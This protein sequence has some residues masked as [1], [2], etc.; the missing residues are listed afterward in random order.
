MLIFARSGLSLHPALKHVLHPA[1]YC[2]LQGTT[3]VSWNI[4]VRFA[5]QVWRTVL[6]LVLALQGTF[7]AVHYQMYLCSLG[8]QILA[9]LWSH[10]TTIFQ[11]RDT[12]RRPN[13]QS[14]RPLVICDVFLHAF[15]VL[16]VPDRENILCADISRLILAILLTGHLT[17]E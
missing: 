9:L 5:L 7:V 8:R 17:D 12:G 15:Q 10:C 3:N 13:H 11:H 2:R 6:P 16:L 4:D 14:L 1:L